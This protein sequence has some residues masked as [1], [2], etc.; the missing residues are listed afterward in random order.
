MFLEADTFT[1]V[2]SNGVPMRVEVPLG[3][4]S[5][6]TQP[7][8][9]QTNSGIRA[10]PQRGSLSQPSSI[11]R[12]PVSLANMGQRGS[13]SSAGNPIS[14]LKS[15]SDQ[16]QN[17]TFKVIPIQQDV[18]ITPK[19][20][21]FKTNNSNGNEL[22]SIFRNQGEPRDV[23]VHNEILHTYLLVMIT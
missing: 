8:A 19:M 21:G 12:G 2:P 16:Q 6:S 20:G 13:V 22:S 18:K 10:S 3:S 14:Q 17:C 1:D 5:P 7:R 9:A 4:G 11:Q 15:S 23:T